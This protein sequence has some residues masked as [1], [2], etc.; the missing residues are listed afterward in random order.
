MPEHGLEQAA[1]ADDVGKRSGLDVRLA[2]EQLVA[3]P[4]ENRVGHLVQGNVDLRAMGWLL[5]GSVP[6]ILIASQFTVR[7]PDRALRLG[8]AGVLALSGVKLLNVP[9]SGWVIA[10]GLAAGFV[11]FATWAINAWVNRPKPVP[12]RSFE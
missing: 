1:V 12:A 2:L 10:I 6:G 7:I 9:E 5:L 3:E 4:V 8:L 11:A